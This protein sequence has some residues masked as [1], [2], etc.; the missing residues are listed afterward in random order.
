MA[1][2]VDDIESRLGP[3]E[4]FVF[5]IGA[6]VPSSI[7]DE[8]PRKFFGMARNIE[9]GGSATVI[10][11]ALVETGSRMDALIFEEFKGTGNMELVLDRKLAEQRVFPAVDLRK[12]GTRRDELLYTETELQAINLLRR[13]ALSVDPLPAMEGML[14]LLAKWP[15]ND[16]ILK[17]ITAS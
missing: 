17:G 7:L 1:A 12:S 15:T 11:T 10:A 5:N 16:E 14:K 6:N 9:G 13:R 3:I 8:T 2:L 4:V